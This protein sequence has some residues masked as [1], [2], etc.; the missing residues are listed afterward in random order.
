MARVTVL[1]MRSVA[2]L[3]VAAVCRPSRS[4]AAR[5]SVELSP[6]ILRGPGDASRL[7]IAI[8]ATAPQTIEFT[9]EGRAE[10][11]FDDT[12]V[13]L[14][15]TDE[16]TFR[17]RALGFAVDN[18]ERD[19]RDEATLIVDVLVEPINGFAGAVTVE[20]EGYP[21]TCPAQVVTP[22]A[23]V[24]CYAQVYSGCASLEV[25]VELTD[26]VVVRRHDDTIDLPCDCISGL[27]C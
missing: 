4:R 25:S 12:P 16:V 1:R 26:G 20:V 7:T 8:A 9:I 21:F 19:F 22:P 27:L 15:V 11:L 18:D 2:I 24:S 23:E 10:E 5:A 13:K 3:L 6:S 17:S 14:E